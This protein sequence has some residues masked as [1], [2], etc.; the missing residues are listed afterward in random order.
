MGVYKMEAGLTRHG[1][2]VWKSVGWTETR[3]FYYNSKGHWV[4]SWDYMK[5]RGGITSEESGLSAIPKTGWKMPGLCGGWE[6][7]S[8]VTV[9]GK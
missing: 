7:N 1:R 4:T 3:Y 2:P 6:R 9:V 5:D 8:K